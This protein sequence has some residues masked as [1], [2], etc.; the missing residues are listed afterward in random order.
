MKEYYK[1][2]L[3]ADD[4]QD[5]RLQL[6]N[7]AVDNTTPDYVDFDIYDLERIGDVKH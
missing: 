3:E 4:Y 1:V 6:H 2:E 5:A 7:M